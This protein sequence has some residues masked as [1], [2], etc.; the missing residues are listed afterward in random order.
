MSKKEVKVSLKDIWPQERDWISRPERYKYLR[1]LVKPDS[2]VFCEANANEIGFESLCVYKTDLSMVV[3]NKYPYNS[4]HVLVLPRRHCG[5][6]VELSEEEYLDVSI[7]LRKTLKILKSSYEA[8][9]YNLGMNHG[10]VA[11]A[12]IPNH[13]HW[14]IVPRWGGDTNFFPL[15]GETKLLPE[16][17]EQTYERLRPL[18]SALGE[19]GET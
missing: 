2:C 4:G 7:L 15:I 16:T 13:L 9:G 5:D 19:S 3:L 6:L 12:G 8:Q 1:R 18:F 10:K 14:H 17:L 11:G